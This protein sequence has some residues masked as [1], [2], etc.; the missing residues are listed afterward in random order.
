[1]MSFCAVCLSDF[2]ACSSLSFILSVSWLHCGIHS[3]FTASLFSFLLVHTL[4]GDYDGMMTCVKG[5]SLSSTDTQHLIFRILSLLALW[6]Q[7]SQ[8][9]P[10]HWCI[11]CPLQKQCWVAPTCGWSYL[12]IIQ[13]YI[14]YIEVF[15]VKFTISIFSWLE[16]A[17]LLATGPSVC[18]S[19]SLVQ[20]TGQIAVKCHCILYV[21][22]PEDYP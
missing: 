1:M 8:Q 20:N 9:Q 17:W 2:S 10:F 15:T 12:Q 16:A 3:A 13:G 11:C 14:R 19:S 7:G 4:R 5:F 22:H 6:L 21:W 18:L